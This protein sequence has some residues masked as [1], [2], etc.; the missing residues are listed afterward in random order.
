[1]RQNINHFRDVTKMVKREYSIR[2]ILPT[3][4]KWSLKYSQGC[5]YVA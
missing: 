3:Q 2:T 4:A 5:G 1:M